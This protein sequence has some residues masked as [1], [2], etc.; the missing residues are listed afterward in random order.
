M[1]NTEQE[2]FPIREDFNP[3]IYAYEV[4][5]HKGLLKVGS[6]SAILQITPTQKEFEFVETNLNKLVKNR[7]NRLDY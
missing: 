2:L 5:E 4:P 1:N 7:S 6:E 3:Q